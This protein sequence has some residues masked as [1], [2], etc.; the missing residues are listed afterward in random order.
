MLV[1]KTCFSPGIYIQPTLGLTLEQLEEPAI[2]LSLQLSVHLV[3]GNKGRPE[4][5]H[6]R[7]CL[8]L[9]EFSE[10]HLNST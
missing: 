7:N 8:G 9:L 10:P 5:G 1:E 2:H 3:E 6:S 4:N